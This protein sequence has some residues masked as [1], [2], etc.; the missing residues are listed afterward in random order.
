MPPLAEALLTYREPTLVRTSPAPSQWPTCLP[1]PGASAP[2]QPKSASKSYP[3]LNWALSHQ[4]ATIPDLR[5]CKFTMGALSRA[6]TFHHGRTLRHG[7]RVVSPP[8]TLS[9]HTHPCLLALILIW[10]S[11]SFKTHGTSHP[12]CQCRILPTQLFTVS[13]QTSTEA[14]EVFYTNLHLD[15]DPCTSLTFLRSLLPQ[16]IHRLHRLTFTMTP[17]QVEGWC[18]GAV[19]SGYGPTKLASQVANP[20]WGGGPAAPPGDDGFYRR[21]WREVVARLAAHADLAQLALTVDM[22]ECTWVYIEDTLMWDDPPD[23]IRPMLKFIYDLYIDV[24]TALCE[25]RGLGGGW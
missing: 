22:S 8:C 5:S 1:K 7:R 13:H 12:Q 15:L 6:I 21:T 10:L 17:A 14:L 4:V 25:L 3:T 11:S 9:S 20:Y 2:S 18:N 23:V 24:V 16:N 19:A